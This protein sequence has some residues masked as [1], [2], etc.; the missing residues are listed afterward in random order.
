MEQEKGPYF[1]DVERNR[2]FTVAL[3]YEKAADKLAAWDVAAAEEL[4][5]KKVELLMP[6]APVS[7]GMAAT[8]QKIEAVQR[9]QEKI[10]EADS[11]HQQYELMSQKLKEIEKEV[12]R[13]HPEL[14][15]SMTDPSKRLFVGL[16]LKD[17]AHDWHL[18]CLYKSALDSSLY[19]KDAYPE[20]CSYFLKRGICLCV[21]NPTG[22]VL[23]T[24]INPSRTIDAKDGDFVYTFKNVATPHKGRI[25]YWH[26]K[27]NFVGESLIDKTAYLDLLPLCYTNQNGLEYLLWNNIQ[28][29]AALVS[30]T[31]REIETNIKPTLIIVA[32]KQSSYYWGKGESM[33]MGYEMNPISADWEKELELYQITGFKKGNRLNPDLKETNLKGTLILFYGMYDERDKEKLLT[34]DDVMALYKI[35]CNYNGK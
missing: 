3:I 14:L 24:G 4:Y 17:V 31:Q 9:K 6:L 8:L 18:F 15:K 5:L 27:Y 1:E 28:L 10:K 32:N 22:G 13:E 11:T 7:Y 30:I 19:D 16:D 34:E 33:W 21:G 12:R 23:I 25:G 20:L 26:Q 29:R 2:I 35:A